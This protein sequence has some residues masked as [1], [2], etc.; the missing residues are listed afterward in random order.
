MQWDCHRYIC[1]STLY[2]SIYLSIFLS[3]YLWRETMIAVGDRVTAI[4]DSNL[5]NIKSAQ[6]RKGS[7]T[8]CLSTEV[9]TRQ[10][11]L[12]L[13]RW[14]DMLNVKLGKCEDHFQNTY[15]FF[16]TYC[17]FFIIDDPY[18][19]IHLVSLGALKYMS[20]WNSWINRKIYKKC[21]SM[22]ELKS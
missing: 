11:L 4:N 7:T 1:L 3:I 19:A 8:V 12:I 22:N 9:L 13:I 14:I 20:R 5:D 2:L 17:F 18:L 6:V 15:C 21:V 10:W 16:S